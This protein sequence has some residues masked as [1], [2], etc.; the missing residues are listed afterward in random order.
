MSASDGIVLMWKVVAS[1]SW[2]PN[3]ELYTVTY[4]HVIFCHFTYP[5]EVSHVYTHTQRI[6]H[7]R[8]F[9]QPH[10]ENVLSQN[11]YSYKRIHTRAYIRNDKHKHT[12]CAHTHTHCE[13]HM[14]IYTN[15]HSETHI[16]FQTLT[17]CTHTFSI[18]HDITIASSSILYTNQYSS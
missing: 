5:D 10:E 4:I 6:L 13:T 8:M 3:E 7:A 18:V 11:I 14:Y 2:S 9:K 17:L 15:T 16:F 12:T 1:N